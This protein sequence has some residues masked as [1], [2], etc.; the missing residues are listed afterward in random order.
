MPE[1]RLARRVAALAAALVTPLALAGCGGGGTTAAPPPTFPTTPDQALWNPCDALPTPT[2]EKLLGVDLD[3]RRGSP[4]A[5]V[6]TFTPAKEGGPALN[7]NYQQ[8]GGTLTQLID[9]F[10]QGT[11]T[12]LTPRVP[13]AD[14][15]RVIVATGKTLALTGFVQ[16][17]EL[18]Q[19]VNLVDPAPYRR[20]ALLRAMTTVL[21][22][23][24]GHAASS[25]LT[26][27]GQQQGRKQ[28]RKQGRQQG[29]APSAA[30]GS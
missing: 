18:V 12:V 16:N 10:G 2:V 20:P 26:G 7:A 24:A 6:C 15:A 9:S 11:A 17:G 23:L 4:T 30:P 13:R 3:V 22:D 19:V 25:G 8:F 1:P 14:D 29:P 5:P 28:G 21:D 27:S